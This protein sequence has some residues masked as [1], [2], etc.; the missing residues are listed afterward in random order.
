MKRFAIP[1]FVVTV[2]AM[3]LPVSASGQLK[4][5]VTVFCAGTTARSGFGEMTPAD[6]ARRVCEAVP[7]IARRARVGDVE[8]TKTRAK[9]EVLVIVDQAG[10][11]PNRSTPSI[12]V[13]WKHA[14]L[15]ID[16]SIELDFPPAT[17]EIELAAQEIV[18]WLRNNAAQIRAPR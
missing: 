7:P 9:A 1:M 11:H 13:T 4:H 3:T 2:G 6:I 18:G 12:Q 15:S 10:Q 8:V 14:K 16:G 5:T 17:D